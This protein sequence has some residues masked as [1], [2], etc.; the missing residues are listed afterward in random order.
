VAEIDICLSGKLK[1][2]LYLLQHP[3]RPNYRSYG[4]QGELSAI[5]QGVVSHVTSVQSKAD[6]GFQIENGIQG[7]EKQ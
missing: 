2:T 3:L 7:Q 6:M 5:E 1:E 4:D